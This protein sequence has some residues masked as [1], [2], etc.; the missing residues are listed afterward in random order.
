MIDTPWIL[1]RALMVKCTAHQHAPLIRL[2]EVTS[3]LKVVK[4][5]P[6]EL[7]KTSRVGVIILQR[8]HLLTEI[9]R[10]RL[11]LIYEFYRVLIFLFIF[12]NSP[13]RSF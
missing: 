10:N 13:C 11:E 2:Y 8:N 6:R 1:A 9:D 3:H 12:L 7:L 4:A 5:S